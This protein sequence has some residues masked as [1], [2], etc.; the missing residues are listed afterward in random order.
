MIKAIY[1]NWPAPNNIRALTTTR[2]G[3]CSISPYSSLNLGSHVGDNIC[4]VLENRTIVT[5]F[6]KLPTEPIWLN[7]IHSTNVIDT[8]NYHLTDCGV[9]DAD[10]SYTQ[11]KNTVSV[12]LTADCLPVLFCSVLGNEIAAAHAGWRGLCN[13]VLENT[14]NCFQTAPANIMA[15]L[16]P[17][18]GPTKFEVGAEVKTQFEAFDLAASTAFQLIDIKQQKYLAD[19]YLLARQRLHKL[20]IT[21]IYG[22]DYCTY[23]QGDLFYSYRRQAITGRMASLIWFE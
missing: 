3:G 15:W 2:Q 23:S 4:H 9:I 13:G 16:G 5:R 1:P 20:G 14:V 17:A 11:Q 21:Q 6:A 18:I 8:T 12:V 7:Q 19:L 22:G 10:A